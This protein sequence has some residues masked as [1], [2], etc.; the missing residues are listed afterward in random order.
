MAFDPDFDKVSLL[1]HMDG[2]YGST[3]FN[4]SSPAAKA[5]AASGNAKVSAAKSKWGGASLALGGSGDY[6]SAPAHADFVFGVGD[7]TVSC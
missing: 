4:D 7:F 6:L 3:T 2:A 5:V 1:L